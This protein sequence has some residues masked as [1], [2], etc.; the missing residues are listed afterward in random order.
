MN[1]CIY[2]ITYGTGPLSL[3]THRLYQNTRQFLRSGGDV[4]R[5]IVV[6]YGAGTER[7]FNHTDRGRIYVELLEHATNGAL[8]E[9]RDGVENVEDEVQG[10]RHDEGLAFLGSALRDPLLCGKVTGPGPSY[11]LSAVHSRNRNRS[12]RMQTRLDWYS[13]RKGP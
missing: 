6:R 4:S 10:R 9:V 13:T 1:M 12:A 3:S 11:L 7:I 5:R 8:L 2:L